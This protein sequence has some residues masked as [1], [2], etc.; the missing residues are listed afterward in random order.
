ML[1]SA[2]VSET[3][4][5]ASSNGI[6]VVLLPIVSVENH[7]EDGSNDPGDDSEGTVEPDKLLLGVDIDQGKVE[8]GGE[9]ILELR[10]RSDNRLH[11]NGSLSEGVFVGGD[12]SE[13]LGHADHDIWTSDNPDV[14]GSRV[15]LTSLVFTG[16]GSD[17]LS[18]AR[19]AL[20][21]VGLE[22][23][24]VDHGETSDEEAS[25]HTFD[26]GEV[27]VAS[28]EE[29]VDQVVEDRDHDD[30]TDRVQVLD[31]VVGSSFEGHAS[32]GGSQVSIN[33][34]V[35]EPEERHEEEDLAGLHGT[36]DL[37]DELL[38]PGDHSGNIVAIGA[39][40]GRCP[41]IY[42]LA[43][44]KGSDGVERPCRSQGQP[45]AAEGLEQDGSTRGRHY[46]A[47]FASHH[48]KGDDHE[49]T[50]GHEPS[51]PETVVTSKEGGRD[52]SARSKVD[53]S[54]EPKI[55]TLDGDVGTD[56]DNLSALESL[57][58]DPATVLLG[59]H[60][61]D[62]RLDTACT[63]TDDNDSEDK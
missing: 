8:D 1:S 18:S 10:E 33:L 49:D 41:E 20:G 34:G 58:P 27:D 42:L 19:R 50:G 23:G 25:I 54:V 24:G 12:G 16:G 22:D 48:D 55:D 2:F 60:R 62:I 5:L 37:A 43:V 47:L 35:A 21:D 28:A 13:D 7:E 32:S 6:K 52:G 26:G 4:T 29:G 14:D 30:D 57:L 53:S 59:N 9:G 36:S 38:V 3:L 11:T 51:D 31:Q 40:L 61:G 63:N 44:L 15:G 56:N 46:V 39:G 17:A 45:N